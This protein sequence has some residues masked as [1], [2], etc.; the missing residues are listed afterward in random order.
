MGNVSCP[1]LVHAYYSLVGNWG[2]DWLSI[3]FARDGGEAEH[4]PSIVI[5]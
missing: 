4:S 5:T 3:T 1:L 2:A